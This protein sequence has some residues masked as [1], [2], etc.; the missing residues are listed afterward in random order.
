M[1]RQQRKHACHADLG[2]VVMGSSLVPETVLSHVEMLHQ[3]VASRGGPT[4]IGPPPLRARE[5]ETQ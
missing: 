5:S 4:R 1:I 3:L 2:T